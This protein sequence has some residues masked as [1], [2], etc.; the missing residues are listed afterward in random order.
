MVTSL[1]DSGRVITIDKP[2]FLNS[3]NRDFDNAIIV[4]ADD[5]FF[6]NDIGDI[7]SDSLPDLLPVPQP[8][9]CAAITTLPRGRVVRTEDGLGDPNNAGFVGPA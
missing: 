8:I 7:I 6:G 3:A 4:F 5:G 9:P 1:A 2:V